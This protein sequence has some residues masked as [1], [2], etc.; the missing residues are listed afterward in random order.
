MLEEYARYI[1]RGT[2]KELESL[3]KELKGVKVLHVNSTKLGGGVAEILHRL[4]PLMND[5]GID[6]HWEVIRGD[7]DFFRVTKR[8][9]NLL[10]MPGER[11]LSHEDILTY[12]RYTFE[13]LN[14]VDTDPYDVVI[15]HDPQP[16]GLVIKR[17]RGQKWI[18]RCHIDVSSP[19][20]ETWKFLET[21]VNSYDAAIFHI[22]EF[23]R[24]G[25]RIPAFVIPPSIDPLHDKNRELEE[26]FINSVLERFRIDPERPVVLQVSRFDRLKDP[27]GVIEAYRIVKRRLDCQLV[28]AGSFASDDPEGEEVYREVLEA[29][30]DDPDI[31]VLNLPPDSHLEINALQRSATVIV[32]KPLREGFG[33]VV[34]EGMWKGKPV[35]GSNIGG[36]R[37]QVI[38]GVTGYL[39]NS[40]EGAAFRIKQLL[41]DEDLRKRLGESARER[42]RHSFLITR[43]LK[44]YLIVLHTLLKVG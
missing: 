11:S 26:D 17:R 34:S 14:H 43:H 31:H 30:G 20:E 39:V 24:E 25:V 36:V 2:L 4:V 42:V 33:L 3:A 21:F 44:D 6:C 5:L 8:I 41:T 23:V 35:V 32:H 10:H 1:D 7:E 22:P 16:A 40:T 37:R 19:D 15:V 12:L 29:K 27:F 28:L 18:W 9:H 38:H 13:N